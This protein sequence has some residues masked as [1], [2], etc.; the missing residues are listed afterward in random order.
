MEQ[1]A[2]ITV[3][4]PVYN[5]AS[6]V[7]R[8]L[9]SIAKQSLRPF[10][11]I[12]VDN[13]SSDNS[14]EVIDRWILQN[15]RN[16]ISV[17]VFDEPKSG[18]CAARNRGLKEVTTP[19]VMFFDSDDTM[20][21][22]HLST[23]ND[24]ISDSPDADIIAW[25]ATIH[26]LNGKK[27]TRNAISR[28]DALRNHIFHSALATQRFAV[29]TSFINGIGDWNEELPGW[30]DLELGVRLLLAKPDICRINN[31]NNVNIYSQEN[32]ITGIG[33]SDNP[34]KWEKSLDCCTASL[35]SA[36]KTS[37][38]VWIDL[39]RC[40]LAGLYLKEGDSANSRRLLG[41]VVSRYNCRLHRLLFKFTRQ[42]VAHGGRG[43]VLFSHLL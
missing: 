42:Y 12:I 34:H 28:T 17:A 9:D 40:I 6:L 5:R 8:T 23:I 2:L 29:K 41:E 3:I 19:Y 31:C 36:N 39:R 1:Q 4:L 24:A 21:P 20:S 15:A 38:T 30:N 10:N 33:F 27:T 13:N 7:S 11:V 37:E 14:R 32:S 18:A 25:G 16:G 43:V 35:V 22:D 26:T